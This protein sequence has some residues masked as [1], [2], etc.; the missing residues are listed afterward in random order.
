MK[1]GKFI[2]FEGLDGAG[3]TTQRDA[4]EKYLAGQG[5]LVLG[6]TYAADTTPF[7]AAAIPDRKVIRI[8]AEPSKG[9]AGT[10]IRS[11]LNRDVRLP[12]ER[13]MHETLAEL[14]AMDR[15]HHLRT[16]VLPAL[17]AGHHV[18]CD[19]YVLSSLAYQDEASAVERLN[20][21]FV[22]ADLTLWI[23]VRAEVAAERRHAAGRANDLLEDIEKQRRV[24]GRYVNLF[25]NTE[26]GRRE[27][28]RRIDGAQHPEEV[29]SDCLHYIK[30]LLD[31]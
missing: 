13:G 27:N 4:V 19:R 14:F 25:F 11:I 7:I 3:T 21:G 29:L 22:A 1:R 24:E 26:W 23:D 30:K 2:V 12:A 18:L 20:A 16:V 9:P 17:E 15:E 8:T 28:T 6:D 31:T 5:M 10:L